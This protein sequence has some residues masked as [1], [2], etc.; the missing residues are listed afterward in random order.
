MLLQSVDQLPGV[1]REILGSR[2]QPGYNIDV[3]LLYF[4]Y[5]D[6]F[7]LLTCRVIRYLHQVVDHALQAHLPSI[8]R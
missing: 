5:I 6:I 3:F 8:V 2:D 4:F 1:I 7:N